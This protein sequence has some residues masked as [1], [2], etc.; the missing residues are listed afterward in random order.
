MTRRVL[1][2]E[3]DPDV[4]RLITLQLAELE[5]AERLGQVVVGAELEAEDAVELGRLRGQHQDRRRAAA[6][7]QRLRHLETVEAGHHQVEDEQVGRPLALPGER[8]GAV[9]DRVHVVARALQVHH[10]QV[11]DVGLVFGDEDRRGHG[12]LS[13]ALARSYSNVTVA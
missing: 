13:R 4:G 3:D 10:Q 1:V 7:A 8:R 11:A 12:R 2:I 5:H 9:A 6:R